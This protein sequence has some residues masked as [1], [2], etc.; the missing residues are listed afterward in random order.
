M[1]GFVSSPF[2]PSRPAFPALRVAGR[3]V[4]VSLTL[5]RW[6]AIPCPLC[7]P[8]AWS[9]C[10]SAIPRVS[11]ACVCACAL[12]A[13]APFLPPWEVWREHLAWFRCRAPVGP[14]HAVRA[15]ARFLPRPRALSVLLWG[16]GRPGPVCPLPGLGLCAPLRA[17][18][19]DHGV[20]APGGGGG[21]VWGGRPVCSPPGGVAGGPRGA[22]GR[23]TSVRP[24]ASPG[25][26]P[27][28]GLSASLSSWRAWPPYCSGSVFAP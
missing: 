4:R 2:P 10:P 26:A 21:G 23:S 27:K 18:P 25:R 5:A 14:F 24:S 20:S 11:P 8:Q 17:A 9:G 28:L 19:C 13:F 16:G 3:P 22:G 6:Y 15:P 1:P 7:V 12:A